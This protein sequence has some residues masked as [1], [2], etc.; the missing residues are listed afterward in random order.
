MR[1]L[2]FYAH[3][4]ETSFVAAL[5]DRTV[6][7]LRAQGHDVD[8]C[9]LNVEGFDPVLSRQERIDYHDIAINRRMVEPYVE[10]LM[11]AEALVF[12]YPVWNFGFP[13][14]LKG[15]F[16]RVFLPGVSFEMNGGSFVPTLR[17]IKKMTAVCTYGA[18]RWRAWTMGDPPRKCVTRMIRVLIAPMARCRYLAHYDMNNTTPE[19]RAAFMAKVEA[20]FSGWRAG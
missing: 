19:K 18:H 3:P 12:V 5:H 9:D 14:I 7:I 6:E 15:V 17:H 16:D 4:V 1:I 8:D 20:H 2:V 11:R 10:R 13:A